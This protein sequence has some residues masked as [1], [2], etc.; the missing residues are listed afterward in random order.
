MKRSKCDMVKN[1]DFLFYNKAKEQFCNWANMKLNLN[2]S[3]FHAIYVDPFVSKAALTRIIRCWAAQ[4]NYTVSS[5]TTIL[6]FSDDKNISKNKNTIHLVWIPADGWKYF[7]SV[8]DLALEKFPSSKVIFLP[9]CD[10]VRQ[11]FQVKNIKRD[12][13]TYYP[14]INKAEGNNRENF[15]TE[16]KSLYQNGCRV[17]FVYVTHQLLSDGCF[18]YLDMLVYDLKGHGIDAYMLPYRDL[19]REC[20][21]PVSKVTDL[22]RGSINSLFIIPV[23][24]YSVSSIYQLTFSVRCWNDILKGRGIATEILNLHEYLSENE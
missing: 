2:L 10:K 16:V 7:N 12:V 24:M 23:H 21:N 1:L 9:S 13:F 8:R 17:I 3:R 19:I 6:D 20:D 22:V 18:K 4:Q 11:K 5:H 15:L 14:R